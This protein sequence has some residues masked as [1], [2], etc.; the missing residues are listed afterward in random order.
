MMAGHGSWKELLEKAKDGLLSKHELDQV[1]AALKDP[2]TT[3]DPYTLLHIIGRAMD[4]SN[5]DLVASYLDYP[6]DPMLSRLAL[7]ILCNYWGLTSKYIDYVRRFLSGVDWDVDGDVRQVAASIAGEVLRTT[8]DDDLF[9]SLLDIATD[10]ND[11]PEMRVTAIRALARALGCGWDDMPAINSK[12]SAED[13]WYR[14][15]LDQAFQRL[16]DQ[17]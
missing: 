10:E 9:R 11:L 1:V 2:G 5:E 7:Q 13:E 8:W 4:A 16:L 3:A 6:Q 12:T 17:R 15:T 14:N